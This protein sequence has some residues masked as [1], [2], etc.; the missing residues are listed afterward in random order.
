MINPERGQDLG[1]AAA[2]EAA[3][4]MK[5]RRK[6]RAPAVSGGTNSC[7]GAFGVLAAATADGDVAERAAVGPVAAA[8]LAEVAGLREIVVV[9]VAEFGVGGVAPRAGEVLR[10]R[11]RRR[12]HLARPCSLPLSR[13]RCHLFLLPPVSG[14]LSKENVVLGF[15]GVY[16]V[17][18]MEG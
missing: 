18:I 10:L 2:R 11:R 9:V 1:G 17:F 8:R 16:W 4:V 3:E 12:T 13:I 5:G 6:T 14:F 7:A 15:W